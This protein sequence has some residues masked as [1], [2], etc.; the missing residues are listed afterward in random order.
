MKELDPTHALV[1]ISYSGN[2]KP[3]VD[4]SPHREIASHLL[5]SCGVVFKN[6]TPLMLNGKYRKHATDANRG[7]QVKLRSEKHLELEIYPKGDTSQRFGFFLNL[8]NLEKD[9]RDVLIRKI[10]EQQKA[11]NHYFFPK[12]SPKS[13]PQ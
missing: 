6:C 5:A 10:I 8:S 1:P 4:L 2:R 13:V 7:V 12:I 11:T 9:A 3:K